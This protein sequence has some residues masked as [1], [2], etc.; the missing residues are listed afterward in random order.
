MAVSRVSNISFPQRTRDG[1]Q[2][3]TSGRPLVSVSP[4]PFMARSA[5]GRLGTLGAALAAQLGQVAVVGQHLLQMHHALWAGSAH[6]GVV[7]GALD[8]EARAA[9]NVLAQVI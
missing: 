7:I 6:D 8:E 3:S 4:G 5:A 2:G 1:H 9:A